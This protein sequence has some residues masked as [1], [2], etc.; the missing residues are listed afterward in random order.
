MYIKNCPLFAILRN[1]NIIT[2]FHDVEIVKKDY[3][4]K[5]LTNETIAKLSI[6][7][8]KKGFDAMYISVDQSRIRC[9]TVKEFS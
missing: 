1:G 9:K 3:F 6:Y 5:E 7:L 8:Y 2:F 4:Y